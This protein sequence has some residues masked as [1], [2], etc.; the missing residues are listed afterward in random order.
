[1]EG[2]DPQ[3]QRLRSMKKPGYVRLINL[4]QS[5]AEL[6]LDGTSRSTVDVGGYSAMV[7]A[8]SGSR[9]VEV[10][11]GAT[12]PFAETID[13]P[14][15][16]GISIL[17]N[18]KKATVISDEPRQASGGKAILRVLNASATATVAKVETGGTVLAESLAPTTGS[19]PY[20]V[21]PGSLP[22][23]VEGKS[24][25]VDVE[26]DEAYTLVV[27]VPEPFL[28]KNSPNRRPAGSTSPMAG[29]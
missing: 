10:K 23:S 18:G 6:M 28:M 9:K 13:V 27:G 1:M 26:A 19:K 8:G 20:E 4:G 21:A 7:I 3:V 2:P 11:T 24:T 5:P 22:I 12:S 17:L 14:S 15:D 16:G 29:G 25:T